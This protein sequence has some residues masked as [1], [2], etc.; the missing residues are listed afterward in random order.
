MLSIVHLVSVQ[1]EIFYSFLDETNYSECIICNNHNNNNNYNNYN[2][3]NNNNK[4]IYKLIQVYNLLV[5]YKSRDYSI[6]HCDMTIIT[7]YI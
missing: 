2:N 5:I 6:Y 1:F 3:N 7:G 4:I